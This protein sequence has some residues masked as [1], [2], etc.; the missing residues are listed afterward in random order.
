MKIFKQQLPWYHG[1]MYRILTN[2]HGELVS[3]KVQQGKPVAYYTIDQQADVIWPIDIVAI[4][5]GQEIHIDLS[6]YKFIDTVML[7]DDQYVVH[8]FQKMGN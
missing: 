4:C 5:T 1:S 2:I 3:I 8:Y 6:K 7:D